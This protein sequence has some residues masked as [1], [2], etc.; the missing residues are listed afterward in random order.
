MCMKD[1]KDLWVGVKS[2]KTKF[3][4]PN[5]EKVEILPYRKPYPVGF[6]LKGC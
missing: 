4:T 2:I 6:Y 3:V 1:L 5:L